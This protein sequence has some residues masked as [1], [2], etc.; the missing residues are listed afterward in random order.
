MFS[1]SSAPEKYQKN[2]LQVLSAFDETRNIAD[3][4]IIFGEI[5]LHQKRTRQKI[6]KSS[7]TSQKQR[8]YPK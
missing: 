7:F 3:A 8:T 6:A 2:I 4:I 5:L 1:I